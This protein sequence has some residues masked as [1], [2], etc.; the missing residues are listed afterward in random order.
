M[1]RALVTGWLALPTPAVSQESGVVARLQAYTNWAV[2]AIAV[3]SV[4]IAAI[5]LAIGQRPRGR[6]AR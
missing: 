4:L 3:G 2:A 6:H 1:L 5:K